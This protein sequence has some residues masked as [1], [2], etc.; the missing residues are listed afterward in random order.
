MIILRTPKGWTG[1]K[2]VDGKQIELPDQW[3]TNGNVW[4]VRKAKYA[5]EVKFYGHPETYLKPDGSYA[6]RTKNAVCIRAVPYD[7]PVVGY[8]NHVTNTLRLWN[9]EPSSQNLPKGISFQDYLI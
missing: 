5:C 7:V 6:I 4:E 3:L 8:R 9:A 2:T 1:P